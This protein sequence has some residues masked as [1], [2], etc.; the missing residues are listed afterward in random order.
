MPESHLRPEQAEAFDVVDGSPAAATARVFLL[1]R[2]LDEMHVN[3]D[4][5]LLGAVGEHGQT[6]VGAP[7][8]V[9]RRN[10]DFDPLLALMLGAKILKQRDGL[11]RGHLKTGEVL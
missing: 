3:R 6:L 8:Q 10:L 9:R 2:S 5:V 7:L 1:I 11:G 4:A